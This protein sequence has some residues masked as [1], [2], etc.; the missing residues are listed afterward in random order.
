MQYLTKEQQAVV[1]YRLSIGYESQLLS[2]GD[3]LLWKGKH[4]MQINCLGY[5]C[6]VKKGVLS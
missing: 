3:W 5:D 4:T 1:E 6:Y 2:N